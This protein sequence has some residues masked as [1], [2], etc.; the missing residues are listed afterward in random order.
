[1]PQG[2]G[3]ASGST[4]TNDNK[5]VVDFNEVR[6]QRLEEKRRKT[7][8]IF[9]KNLLSVYTVTGDSNMMPIELIDISET[10]CGFQIPYDAKN[11]WPTDSGTFPLRL[12][13]SQD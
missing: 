5:H 6:A 11:I 4:P 7:E 13:F 9:F 12:Y 8:R 1:M 3:N 2:T 10:G